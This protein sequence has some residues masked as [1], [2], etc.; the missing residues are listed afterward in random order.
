MRYLL[1][2]LFTTTLWADCSNNAYCPRGSEIVPIVPYTYVAPTAPSVPPRYSQRT[3]YSA[4]PVTVGVTPSSEGGQTT[5]MRFPAQGMTHI[6][7]EGKV[8]TCFTV[9]VNTV[10]CQ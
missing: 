4:P 8:T 9:G 7:Q 2:I 1:L 3:G 5:I 10:V 6:I